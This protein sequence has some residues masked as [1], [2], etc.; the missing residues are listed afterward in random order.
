M[1]FLPND[2]LFYVIFPLTVTQIFKMGHSGFNLFIAVL[3]RDF[4]VLIVFI[5][6][7][8]IHLGAKILLAIVICRIK[9]TDRNIIHNSKFETVNMVFPVY[10]HKIN[11]NVLKNNI[12]MNNLSYYIDY[13]GI[14]FS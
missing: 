4:M 5:I 2:I 9:I 14:L 6:K 3:W 11:H 12:I 10:I 7:F 8:S 1:N 13:S